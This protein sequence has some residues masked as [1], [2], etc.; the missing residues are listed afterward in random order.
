MNAYKETHKIQ[1]AISKRLNVAISFD[2][3]RTL[4][5]AGMTLHRWSELECGDGND[6]ASWSIERDAE[7]N[8]PYLCTY[9]HEGKSR[10]RPIPDRETGALKRVH[11]LCVVLGLKYYH[12]TDPRGCSLYV[13]TENLTDQNYNNGVAI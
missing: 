9:P 3:A 1:E 2:D 11:K 13:S 7:T 6:Y 10:R 8:K 5:R 12:Q 4:R